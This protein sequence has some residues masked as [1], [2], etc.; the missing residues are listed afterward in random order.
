MNLDDRM[1]RLVVVTCRP[2]GAG[3]TL[4][5]D[6]GEDVDIWCVRAY[7]EAA[8]AIVDEQLGRLED[9]D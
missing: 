3:W 9:D 5:V 7:L 8:L 2:I 4:E 1:P 6:H